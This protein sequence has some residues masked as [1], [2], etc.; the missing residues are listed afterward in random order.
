MQ[1]TSG[2]IGKKNRKLTSICG[3]VESSWDL[4]YFIV[5]V[6]CDEGG[7]RVVAGGQSWFRLAFAFLSAEILYMLRSAVV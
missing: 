5:K 4:Q 7:C 1:T 3:A 6:V 2:K